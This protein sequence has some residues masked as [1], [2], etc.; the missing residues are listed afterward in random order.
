MRVD[1]AATTGRTLPTILGQCG[2]PPSP[3]RPGA[4]WRRREAPAL[5]RSPGTTTTVGDAERQAGTLDV[6]DLT[7]LASGN[8]TGGTYVAG[9][10]TTA[11]HV[12]IGG[13]VTSLNA[14]IELAG[15]GASARGRSNQRPGRPHLG[16]EGS[17]SMTGGATLSTAALADAG[18][19]V[20][21]GTLA[22]PGLT[23]TGLVSAIDNG[24]ATSP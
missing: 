22:T 20:G 16:A 17:I 5:R 21:S 8:L 19:F 11:G 4:P 15:P 10:G 14:I 3:S 12:Q 23:N 7:N 13:D 24:P 18:S 9:S 1:L 2:T 6:P